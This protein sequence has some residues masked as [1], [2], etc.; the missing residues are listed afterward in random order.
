[1]RKT[2]ASIAAILLLVACQSAS[3]PA[4]LV[5]APHDAANPARMEVLHVPSVSVE[6][7][8]VA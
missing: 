3:L 6:T 8:G 2:L 7:N 4:M 5:D 1:M